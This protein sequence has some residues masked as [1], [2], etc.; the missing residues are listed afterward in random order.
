ML[1]KWRLQ[2]LIA[3]AALAGS[4]MPL[5]A[6]GEQ[7]RA[8]DQVVRIGVTLVQVDAVVTDKQGKRVT[9]LKPQDF[10][11]LVDGKSEPI[12]NF[13]YISTPA[14]RPIA[15]P[16]ARPAVKD[17]PPI[18]PAPLEPGQV[19]R[20]FVL[21]IDD[22]R[23]SF[24]SLAL[25]RRGLK[26]FVDDQMQPGDLVAVV[27]TSGGIGV[28]QQFTS[29]KSQL[30]SIIDHVKWSPSG[31][32]R[33][34]AIDTIEPGPF[35]AA[36]VGRGGGAISAAAARANEGQAK[37]SQ[38]REL[39]YQRGSLDAVAYIISGLRDL[40]GRKTLVLFSDGLN[41]FRDENRADIYSMDPIRRI[42]EL[43][44]RSSV[45]VNTVDAR[46]LQ[47]LGFNAADNVHMSDQELLRE[48][49]ARHRDLFATQQGLDYLAGETGGL[50]ERDTSDLG[51]A[52]RRVVDDQGG[53]YL[54]G[55]IPNEAIFK[56]VNGRRP[57]HS[58]T[59]KVKKAGLRV[60][61]RKG[62]LGETDAEVA[63][64]AG[65]PGAADQLVAALTS[66]F[67][68]QDIQL[69]LTSLFWNSANGGSFIYSLLHVDP[70]HLTFTDEP[71]GWHRA[72]F[73]VAEMVFGDKGQALG[74]VTKTQTIRVSDTGY[75][76]INRQGLAF[77]D[78][79]PLKSTGPLQ[80]R[81]AIRDQGSQ[82]LGTAASFVDVPDINSG[83]LL[84]SGVFLRPAPAQAQHATGAGLSPG[85]SDEALRAQQSDLDPAV[86]V[87][88][89]GANLDLS[90][91]VYN[92][93]HASQIPGGAA[94]LS[95]QIRLFREG[96]LVY[97]G[98]V[99][100]FSPTDQSDAKRLGA[101]MN[102]KLGDQLEPGDYV[103]QVVCTDKAEKRS[104]V[105]TQWVDLQ[106]VR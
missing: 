58:V 30:Y 59:V 73:D 9:D 80:Y 42:I 54:I 63:A 7:N 6:A 22:L 40:P 104:A 24:E 64:A 94:D 21:V 39:L 105:A 28:L 66:P 57:F 1:V 5:A 74:R 78:R 16:I 90:L 8:D 43:A 75:Q 27:R 38:F 14:G 2:A 25:V 11:I 65:Q 4:T 23:M 85:H 68:K 83:Q 100:P 13:S 47:T 87:F 48:M 103:L 49:G 91:I 26:S 19:R 79:F 18:P 82:K 84:L 56:T 44:N 88:R 55:F 89:A 51:R 34:S 81:V 12:T 53:Y 106:L 60:R 17:A 101:E 10:E 3:L 76:Y 36:G 31:M 77:A 20:I 98:P 46:G 45:V 70:A 71:G 92:A 15:P 99:V 102:F 32:G 33:M 97:A 96:N 86:R 72:S 93:G 67:A 62:F 35:Q 29:N 69:R 52:L 95:L 61:S 50:S 37:L 41:L